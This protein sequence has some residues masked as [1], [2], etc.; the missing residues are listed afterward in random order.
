MSKEIGVVICNFNKKDFVLESV[1]SVM[2]S[3]GVSPDILLWI[4]HLRMGVWRL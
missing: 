1:Q 4:T 2:E 3:V